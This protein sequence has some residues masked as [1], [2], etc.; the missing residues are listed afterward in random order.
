MFAIESVNPAAAMS[1]FMVVNTNA[2]G[3][4]TGA[5]EVA[6]APD[7]EVSLPCSSN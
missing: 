3:V 2:N 4:V 5:V 6:S 1:Y 7:R